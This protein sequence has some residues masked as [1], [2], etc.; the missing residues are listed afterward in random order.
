MNTPRTSTDFSRKC[1]DRVSRNFSIIRQ[2]LEPIFNNASD[3]NRFK[4]I[5]RALIVIKGEKIDHEKPSKISTSQSNKEACA[6]YR[7]KINASFR[8]LRDSLEH[9][10]CD[11][12]KYRIFTRAGILEA[13]IDCLKSK[14]GN[15]TKPIPEPSIIHRAPKRKLEDYQNSIEKRSPTELSTGSISPNSDSDYEQPNYFHRQNIIRQQILSQKLFQYQIYHTK[16]L[17]L[18]NYESMKESETKTDVV[19]RPWM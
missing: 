11:L 19:F 12:S 7:S 18:Q 8:C 13:T 14:I 5:K 15:I 3:W 16:M 6:Q 9:S 17:W 2:M 4:I 10:G 1:R